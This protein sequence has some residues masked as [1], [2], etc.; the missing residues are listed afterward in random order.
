MLAELKEN[1]DDR[2]PE[3]S[4]FT[5]EQIEDMIAG[6]QPD[7][8]AEEQAARLTPVSYTHLDVYK[9]QAPAQWDV[10]EPDF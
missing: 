1:T 6:S 8:E 2:D 10:A 5:T 4:G 9:R 3:L 7:R